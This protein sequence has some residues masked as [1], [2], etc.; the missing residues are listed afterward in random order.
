MRPVR[1]ARA[2][3]TTDHA[4]FNIHRELHNPYGVRRI[5]L[6]H[7]A[8]AASIRRLAVNLM[9]HAEDRLPPRLLEKSRARE[10]Q[11][12]SKAS[13]KKPKSSGAKDKGDDDDDDDGKEEAEIDANGVAE[14]GVEAL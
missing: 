9:D 12:A 1:I 3:A 6:A 11:R 5:D 13:E 4:F 8:Q 14:S 2:R 7:E 10:L